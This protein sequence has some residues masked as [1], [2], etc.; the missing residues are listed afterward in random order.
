MVITNGRAGGRRCSEAEAEQVRGAPSYTLRGLC[1]AL[2]RINAA[3]QVRGAP[4]YTL[5]GLCYALRRING[6]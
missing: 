3:E 4:S 1:Y 2:R 5:R 6:G